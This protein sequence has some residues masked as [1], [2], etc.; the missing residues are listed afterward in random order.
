MMKTTT[1]AL[2]SALALFG[3]APAYAG[4]GVP[5]KAGGPQGGFPPTTEA[6]GSATTSGDAATPSGSAVKSGSRSGQAE[7]TPEPSS[8]GGK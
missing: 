6:G 2:A 1:I 5:P 8:K 4:N 7:E 3:G